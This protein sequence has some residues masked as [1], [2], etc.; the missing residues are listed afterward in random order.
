M[1]QTNEILD[2]S[3]QWGDRGDVIVFLHYFGGAAASWRWTANVLQSEYQ[4]LAFNLLG[5]GGTPAIHQLSVQH[6][7]RA[8]QAQLEY[9]QI[10][11]YCLVGHSMGGKI[12]LQMAANQPSGLEQLI[13]IAPSPPSCEPM[14]KSEKEKLLT[15]PN[16]RQTAIHSVQN[17]TVGHISAVQRELAIQTHMSMSNSVRRW[18][19]LQGMNE[20]IADQMGEIQI[21]V[22]AILST[23]DPVIPYDRIQSELIDLIPQTRFVTTSGV[24]H[25]MPFE[26]PNFLATSIR[27]TCETALKSIHIAA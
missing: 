22:T 10:K 17:A 1:G 13:L 6:Y 20:S 2:L 14:P 5:F 3:L 18:W 19:L 23:D 12:A 9:L 11:S 21:P 4:C 25:L 8:V 15:N 7:A 24:G 16:S 26:S 27:N